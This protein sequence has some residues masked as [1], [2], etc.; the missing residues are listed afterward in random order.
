MKKKILTHLEKMEFVCGL[1][2]FKEYKI[3]EAEQLLDCLHKLFA[4]FGWMTEARVDYIL[5]AGLQ[6]QIV[7]EVQAANN[8][9]KEITQEEIAYWI[10]IGK[11]I[12]RDNYQYAKETGHCKDLAEWGVNWF[13]KFQE[14]G[15]LKPWEF[16][17][18]EIESD[19]RREL[20]LNTKWI[21]E[22]S[23]AAKSKNKIWKMFIL[24]SIEKNKNLDK[25]I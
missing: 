5:H 19:A 13:N 24:Q 9:E 3:E 22:S 16:P 11:Q 18:Q 21:D 12:F 4:S 20:R 15:I 10:E 25:L 6:S 1:K 8:Q 14:K 2:Q 17:V 23:V 7:Q